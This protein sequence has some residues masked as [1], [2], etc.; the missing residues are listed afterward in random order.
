MVLFPIILSNMTDL[1][2][3]S[4]DLDI[5][6]L[7][8]FL[9]LFL[10]TLLL[11][12]YFKRRITLKWLLTIQ[13]NLEKSILDTVLVQEFNP[14]D[15]QILL[16]EKINVLI[17]N[18]Y[19]VSL[20]IFILGGQFVLSVAYG[21]SIS[22]GTVIFIITMVVISI[23]VNL[24]FSQKLEDNMNV[25]QGSNVELAKSIEGVLSS[26]KYLNI[27]NAIDFG[28]QVLLGSLNDRINSLRNRDSYAALV[29]TINIGISFFTQLGT[30]AIVL[31]LVYFKKLTIGN[32]MAML[33]LL[34]YIIGPLTSFLKIKNSIDSTK[35]IRKDFNEYSKTVKNEKNIKLKQIEFNSVNFSYDNEKN[36]LTNI[37]LNFDIGKKYLILGHS[38]SGKSTLLNLI[39]LK[40]KN[41]TGEIFFNEVLG[42]DIESKNIY[43]NFGYIDQ[44]L[45]LLPVS[46]SE[47]I[48]LSKDYDEQKIIDILER[49][50]LNNLVPK[51]N[52]L[53]TE[54]QDNL[55]GGEI[56]RILLGRLL[57]HDVGWIVVDEF[58]SSLDPLNAYN[59]E[60][61]ILEYE[62]KTVIHIT[63]K[64]NKKLFD[65]YDEL[66]ILKNGEIAYRGNVEIDE[67]NLEKYY[68]NEIIKEKGV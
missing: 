31:L 67:Q 52:N 43:N 14:S 27:Y 57:Y 26:T 46:I 12:Q 22:A 59:M 35:S 62:D 45:S 48:A 42:K 66:I 63:H 37:N 39:F 28:R 65:M 6:K 47:N 20:S 4:S 16:G 32:A 23:L 51:R 56:Q 41:F 64:Y 49:V 50:N 24:S 1:I 10:V 53:V 38:G 19:K 21:V 13:S 58:T 36:V 44:S 68:Q 40:Y 9:G 15:V 60:K 33:F 55:S 7:L 17:G 29:E 5:K 2:M 30:M 61:E 11:I 25:V 34:Q 18:Y 8:L 54:A 3:N